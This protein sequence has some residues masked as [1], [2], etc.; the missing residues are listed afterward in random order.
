MVK[1]PSK[2]EPT[3]NL[4][5]EGYASCLGILHTLRFRNEG[6]QDR[7]SFSSLPPPYDF[8]P[9]LNSAQLQLR[10]QVGEKCFAAPGGDTIIDYWPL[11]VL[12]LPLKTII[13]APPCILS[14]N[15]STLYVKYCL[16]LWCDVPDA[17]YSSATTVPIF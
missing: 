6:R 11:F 15:Q 14:I 1:L 3:T 5:G 4:G 17:P 10:L 9:I 8:N 2:K 13:L 16:L 12:S 7:P